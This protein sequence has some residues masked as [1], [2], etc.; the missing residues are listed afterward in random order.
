MSSNVSGPLTMM[1]LA[2]PAVGIISMLWRPR[3]ITVKNSALESGDQVKL[4]TD[5][6]RV[7]VTLFTRPV[8]LSSTIRR[9]RSLS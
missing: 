5:R 9:Q 6:S 7:S 1:R 3:S 8:A 2:P 4:S